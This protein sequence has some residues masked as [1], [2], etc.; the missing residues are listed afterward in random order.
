[1]LLK[2][3]IKSS[4]YGVA[5]KRLKSCETILKKYGIIF[6]PLRF[7]T[8]NIRLTQ[9]FPIPNDSSVIYISQEEIDSVAPGGNE[10][11]RFIPVKNINNTGIKG[12]IHRN[13]QNVHGDDSAELI[14]EDLR[15]NQAFDLS[16]RQHQA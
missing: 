9:V 3:Q 2:G 14:T 16:A 6:P 7:G 8:I 5:G 4:G 11:W 13:R 1:M 15:Y 12:F 10:W